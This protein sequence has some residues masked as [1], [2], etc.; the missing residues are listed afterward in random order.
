M[1]AVE[2]ACSA[3]A[4]VSVMYALLR[5]RDMYNAQWHYYYIIVL[6][7]WFGCHDKVCSL[8]DLSI[9][10]VSIMVAFCTCCDTTTLSSKIHIHA[11]AHVVCHSKSKHEFAPET[12]SQT[13]SQRASFAGDKLQWL[14]L[15]CSVPW[16]WPAWGSTGCRASWTA[17]KLTG[18]KSWW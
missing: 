2:H 5:V 13:W 9:V 12:A 1:C 8:I 17:R 14:Q 15:V 4:L 10:K 18:A 6:N 3:K 16:V 7:Q 11:L